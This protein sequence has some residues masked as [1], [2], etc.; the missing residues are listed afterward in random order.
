MATLPSHSYPPLPQPPYP[1]PSPSPSTIGHRVTYP[2]CVPTLSC[3]KC[4][5]R[6]PAVSNLM[7]ICRVSGW[8]GRDTGEKYRSWTGYPAGWIRIWIHTGSGH[9]V[10]LVNTGATSGSSRS[11][12]RIFRTTPKWYTWWWWMINDMINDKWY[13]Y[14]YIYI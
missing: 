13:T 8:S 2:R 3:L 4:W 12:K 9:R 10:R 11:W 5:E 1:P 7:T 14:T 6:I